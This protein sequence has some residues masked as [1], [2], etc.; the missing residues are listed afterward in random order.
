MM[1]RQKPEGIEK[2]ILKG[3]LKIKPEC[4]EGLKEGNTALRITF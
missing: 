2:Q 3:E 1:D 4:P